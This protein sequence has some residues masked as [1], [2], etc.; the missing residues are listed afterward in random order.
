[1]EGESF[2]PG[3]REFFHPLLL[4]W[5]AIAYDHFEPGSNTER[6]V[7][8]DLWVESTRET[9]KVRQNIV[10]SDPLQIKIIDALTEVAGIPHKKE[11]AEIEIPEKL[12]GSNYTVATWDQIARER[13]QT[14]ED[15]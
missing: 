6:T 13:S 3:K 10:L 2:E 1:M 15:K 7:A 12:R 14:E 4:A 11:K 5:D 9:K 8:H